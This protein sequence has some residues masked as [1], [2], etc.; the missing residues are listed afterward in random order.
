MKGGTEEQRDRWALDLLTLRKVGAWALTE[1]G[2]GSDAFGAM[3]ATARKVGNE[4]ILNGSKTFIT[5]APYADTIVFICKLDDGRT[6][7]EQRPVVNFVVEPGMEGVSVSRPLRK[8]GLHSSP[9]GEVTLQDVRVG[10]DRLLGGVEPAPRVAV[11]TTTKQKGA[12]AGSV[13]TAERASMAAIALGIIER[14]LELSVEYAKTRVQFGKPI[15]SFQMIQE[16]LARME[17]ARMNVE[18]MLLRYI[19]LKA[20]G[21]PVSMSHASAM[22]LYAASAATS[23]TVDAMQIWGGN[24]YMS[25]NHIEQLHRDASVLPIYAGTDQMQILSI[26]KDLLGPAANSR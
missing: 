22:K 21:E 15:G 5:N 12:S 17:V 20:S 16:K 8:M 6:A 7:R 10:R 11:T 18:G 25:E 9:T 2:S 13:F 1:P 14:S 24:G 26:A 23:V 19:G 3:R 4:Y